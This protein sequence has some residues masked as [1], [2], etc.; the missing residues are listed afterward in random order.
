M[1]FGLERSDH[2]LGV[3][4]RL[5]DLQGHLANEPLL[6]LGPEDDVKTALNELQELSLRSLHQF[7]EPHQAD[8]KSTNS[9]TQSSRDDSR[10]CR[11]AGFSATRCL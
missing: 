9:P 2:P 11:N 7:P 6:L 3:H 10:H 8:L 1:A 4:P 5:D